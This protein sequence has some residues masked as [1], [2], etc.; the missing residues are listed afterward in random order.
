ML[1][2]GATSSSTEQTFD[3]QRAEA[4]WSNNVI[5]EATGPSGSFH[6]YPRSEMKNSQELRQGK[7]FEADSG[8]LL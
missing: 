4:S 7:R 8:V 6:F 2:S 3:K 5:C 1:V